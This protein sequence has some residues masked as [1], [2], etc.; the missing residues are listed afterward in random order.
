[1]AKP[2]KYPHRRLYQFDQQMLDRIDDYRFKARHKTEADAV[3]GLIELGLAFSEI[4]SRKDVAPELQSLMR[5]LELQPQPANNLVDTS[6]EKAMASWRAAKQAIDDR[7]DN[8]PPSTVVERSS[9]DRSTA[10]GD[11]RRKR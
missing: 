10:S 7:F 8:R 3:R 11:R 2:T 6:R 4:W 9:S 1:M 5:K